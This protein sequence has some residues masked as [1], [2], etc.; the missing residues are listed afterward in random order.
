M[1]SAFPLEQRLQKNTI[2]P[3]FYGNLTQFV[4][5]SKRFLTNNRLFEQKIEHK[6]SGCKHKNAQKLTSIYLPFYPPT[7]SPRTDR[8]KDRSAQS[9]SARFWLNLSYKKLWSPVWISTRSR[10]SLCS[11]DLPS[12]Q[13][14]I[15]TPAGCSQKNYYT[16]SARWKIHKGIKP[17]TAWN[18]ST[19]KQLETASKSLLGMMY[20]EADRSG[21]NHPLWIHHQHW[22]KRFSIR[23]CFLIFLPNLSYLLG[24]S[25]KWGVLAEY[26]T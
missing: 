7:P 26:N 24:F 6:M 22:G 15:S 1:N 11:T 2:F 4:S 3:A 18:K 20:T 17:G 14:P 13:S 8:Y 5:N 21:Q 23:A 9:G 10:Q 25:Q 19:I 16:P 12:G